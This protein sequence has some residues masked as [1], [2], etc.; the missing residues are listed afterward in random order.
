MRSNAKPRTPCA[1]EG[2]RNEATQSR[3][4]T[5]SPTYQ[6]QNITKN[7]RESKEWLGQGKK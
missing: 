1:Q 2:Y 4:S 6:T 7:T 3:P 5:Q